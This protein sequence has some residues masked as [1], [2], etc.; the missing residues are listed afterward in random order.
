MDA[1]GGLV[2]DADTRQRLDTISEDDVRR[3][4]RVKSVPED[5]RKQL[6]VYGLPDI[7]HVRFR[8]QTPAIRR[9]IAT[10]V[11]LQYHKDAQDDAI[12]SNKQLMQLMERRGEWSEAKDARIKELQER[13]NRGLSTLYLEGFATSG[14]AWLDQID[15]LAQQ[16]REALDADELLP[17]EDEMRLQ[18]AERSEARVRFERWIG[19]TP[20]RR[21]EYVDAASAQGRA[22]YSPDA[23]LMWLTQHRPTETM[24]DVLNEIDELRDKV[25]RFIDVSKERAELL[26]LQVQ[27]AKIFSDSVESRRDNTEELTRVYFTTERCGE[28]GKAPAPITATPDGLWEFPEELVQWLLVENYF[29]HNNIPDEA[30]PYLETFGFIR[31]EGR[32]SASDLSAESPEGPSSKT[33]SSSPAKTDSSSSENVPATA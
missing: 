32:T 22:E 17:V 2:V 23:D 30:R 14:R 11:Q 29:W 24:L 9:K 33:D 27:R 7:S 28:N 8:H 5:L 18:D 15:D 26:E 13:T 16:Y 3:G 31:A 12:L 21:A 6:V 10:V 19:Y 4:F 25:R 1:K 20:E